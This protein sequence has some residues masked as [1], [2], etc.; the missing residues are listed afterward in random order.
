[1]IFKKLRQRNKK[2]IKICITI[3]IVLLCIPGINLIYQ[4]ITTPSH[5]FKW[6][7]LSFKKTPKQT[8]QSYNRIFKKYSTPLVSKYFLAA[9]AQIE[10]SGDP[11]ASSY[12]KLRITPKIRNIYSP[13]SS[14]AGLFQITN[15]TFKESKK[16]CITKNKIITKSKFK[17]HPSC[18][19][20]SFF[21]RFIPSHSTQMVSARLHYYLNNFISKYKKHLNNTQSI[22]KLSSVIHLC[23]INRARNFIKKKMH[24]SKMPKCGDHNAYIFYKKLNKYKKYFIRISQN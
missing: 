22:E 9:L 5:I 4:T 20:N 12:W 13:A 18:Y 6:I 17:K 19:L 24:F 16:F 14:A 11:L 10:S 8:W 21:S 1:M 7:P 2:K 23:G 3:T 15:H